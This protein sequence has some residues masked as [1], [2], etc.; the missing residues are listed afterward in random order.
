ME[1]VIPFYVFGVIF[2]AG[3]LQTLTGFGF[4]LVAA[5][6]LSLVLQPKNAVIV[7]LFVGMMMKAFVVYKTWDEGEFSRVRLLFASSLAG[8]LPGAFILRAVDDAALKLIIGA[9]LLSATLAMKLNCTVM[10]RSHGPAQI[11]AGFLSGL[12]GATTSLNGPPV[13]MYMMNEGVEKTVMR[14]NLARYFLLGNAGTLVI[15]FFF[16]TVRT[17]MAL[18]YGLLC[19]PAIWLSW[20]LGDRV[21]RMVDAVLFRR[22]ALTLISLSALAVLGS[23]AWS[24][25]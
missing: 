8:A 16:G 23:G 25:H 9:A 5:P 3:F 24:L 17:E 4:A 12:M 10:I 21:F 11:M 14:A 2:L 18:Y 13:V 15:S 19:I 22:I 7:V 6:L 1:T 20:V